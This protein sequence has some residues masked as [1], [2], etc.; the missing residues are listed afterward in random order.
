MGHLLGRSIPLFR[1]FPKG[2]VSGTAAVI[3][4]YSYGIYL[5]HGPLLWLCFGY[6][7]VSSVRHWSLYGALIV[8]TPVTL[9]HLVEKPAI[10][11]GRKIAG[12]C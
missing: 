10:E 2:L 4:R 11:F 6:P 5:S 9:Y 3:A 8:A 1:E 12:T 7:H